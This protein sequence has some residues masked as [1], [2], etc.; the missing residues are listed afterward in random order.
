MARRCIHA[1]QSMESNGRRVAVIF[2]SFKHPSEIFTLKDCY[3]E[4]LLTFT[5][6]CPSRIRKDRLTQ[7]G[8]SQRVI[9]EIFDRDEFELDK[10][11]Q[12]VRDTAYLSD[13]FIRNASDNT[14]KLGRT[15]DR[16]LEIIFASKIHSP[17]F[18]ERG[19]GKAFGAAANS[20]CL[21]R[22]VGAAV[23]DQQGK[24]LATGCNDVPKFGGGLYGEEA[25]ATADHRCFNWREGVCHNDAEKEKIYKEIS[26]T[27]FPD[28]L[29]EK[30]SKLRQDI[31]LDR[32]KS[33]R[34]KDL[35]EFSRSVHA[36]MDAIVSV[37]RHGTGSTLRGTLFSKTFPCHSCARHIV[38][39]GITRVVFVEPYAKSLALKLHPDSIT[40]R[41]EDQEGAVL[42]VQYEGVSPKVF[43]RFFS[44]E[45]SRKSAGAVIRVDPMLARPVGIPSSPSFRDQ[46]T[47]LALAD[48]EPQSV[49]S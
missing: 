43:P 7:K 21:S 29:D 12:K 40:L 10:N 1:N 34:I 8:V 33:T 11:G 16:Y 27:I 15:L 30:R 38:A 44:V 18:D 46:A 37:G 22:Q 25:D 14:V 17:N 35:I 19:M 41:E 26:E 36:E 5:V 3:E 48:P 39:A 6:F 24:L 42:F 9:D 13:F 47:R 45:R 4:R 20:V 23:Y 32:I 2:D 49:V 28:R 31:V